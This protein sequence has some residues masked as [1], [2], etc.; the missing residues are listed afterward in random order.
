MARFVI[1]S[2]KYPETIRTRGSRA[3]VKL[4]SGRKKYH[5]EPLKRVG[6]HEVW[7]ENSSS[8]KS[9]NGERDAVGG[10]DLLHLGCY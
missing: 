10:E 4:R 9:R 1:E 7:R 3:V 8:R 5:L 6:L 2:L